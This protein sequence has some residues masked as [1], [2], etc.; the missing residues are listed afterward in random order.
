MQE[1]S[2]TF[3]GTPVADPYRWLEDLHLFCLRYPS[4]TSL[5]YG[6]H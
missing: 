2:G 6:A 4:I 5:A 1:R 3:Y